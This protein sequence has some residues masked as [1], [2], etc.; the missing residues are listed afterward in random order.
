M[1]LRQYRDA[2]EAHLRENTEA[3]RNDPW[4]E[5]LF[6]RLPQSWLPVSAG[7]DVNSTE[8]VPLLDRPSGDSGAGDRLGPG[9]SLLGN[10]YG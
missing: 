8:N 5:D 10:H 7:G 1:A 9:G 2:E 3:P 6:Y 4:S